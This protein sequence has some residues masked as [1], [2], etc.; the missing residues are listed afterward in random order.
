MVV[1]NKNLTFYEKQKAEWQKIFV[2]QSI[3]LKGQKEVNVFYKT[4]HSLLFF[5]AFYR[6]VNRIS[7]TYKS[8]YLMYVTVGMVNRDI[9]LIMAKVGKMGVVWLIAMVGEVG[10]LLINIGV[11]KILLTAVKVEEIRMD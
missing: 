6:E 11:G 10:V 5:L 9:I 7:D 4:L 8:V 3:K 2:Y 1:L